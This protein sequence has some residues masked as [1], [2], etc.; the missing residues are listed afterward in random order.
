M[1]SRLTGLNYSESELHLYLIS[2][3]VNGIDFE[4]A[5]RIEIANKAKNI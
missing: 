2:F 4:L 1:V 5:I 3:S